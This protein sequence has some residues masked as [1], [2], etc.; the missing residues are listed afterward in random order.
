MRSNQVHVT[1]AAKRD[2]PSQLENDRNAG[3][4]YR[5]QPDF[6]G[7]SLEAALCGEVTQ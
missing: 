5:F 6:R 7:R 2:I 3:N 1:F 4:S